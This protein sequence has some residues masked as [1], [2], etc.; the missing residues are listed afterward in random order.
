MQWK[1]SAKAVERQLKGRVKAVE[2][3]VL[4]RRCSGGA[5]EGAVGRTSRFC[6]RYPMSRSGLPKV[7][8]FS[9]AVVR[10]PGDKGARTT[11]R[12]G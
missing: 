9:R 6:L 4:W 1:G 2:K 12:G 8:G 11:S 3:E 7:A 5:L 10:M